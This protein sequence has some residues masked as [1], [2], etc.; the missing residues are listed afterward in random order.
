MKAVRC[1][2]HLQR[3]AQ[4]L[5]ASRSLQPGGADGPVFHLD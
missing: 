2:A 1:K 5:D 3:A 4:I